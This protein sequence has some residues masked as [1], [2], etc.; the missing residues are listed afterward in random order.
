MNKEKHTTNIAYVGPSGAGLGF[1]L[2]GMTVRECSTS[3][4]ALRA[5]RELKHEG[6]HGI[7]FVDE[8][9]AEDKLQEIGKLNEDPLPAILL[10]PNPIDP[11]NVAAQSLQNLII[12]A[13]GSDIVSNQS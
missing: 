8:S 5:I 10:L 4:E 13:V 2:S 9:L 11:K 6:S 7:I 12:K 1:Q 3:D